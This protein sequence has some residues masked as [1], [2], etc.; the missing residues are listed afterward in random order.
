MTTPP[1][2][3]LRAACRAHGVRAAYLL[4]SRAQDG[5][6]VLAGSPADGTG[7]DLDIGLLFESPADFSKL[8]EV[9]VAF[10]DV[11]APLAVDLVPLQKVDPLFQWE[12]VR[13]ERVYAADATAADSWELYVMRR[14][15][16]ALPLQRALERE[17]FGVATT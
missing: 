2:T 17:T 11:F 7:S 6:A 13:G 14:A 12:A 1:E 8:A 10:E 3:A 5:L 4:G 9:Q 16:E 15:A